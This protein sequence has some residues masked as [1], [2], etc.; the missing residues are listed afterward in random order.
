MS[1]EERE[2]LEQNR[3]GAMGTEDGDHGTARRS[4]TAKACDQGHN[5]QV[6][7]T[8]AKEKEKTQRKADKEKGSERVVK[9][10]QKICEDH[11]DDCGEDL[12]SL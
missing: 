1:L 6:Y 4:P 3:L 2:Q 5:T 7:P 10:K 11:H 12:S 8:N 9:K